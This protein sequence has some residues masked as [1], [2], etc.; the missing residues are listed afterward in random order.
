MGRLNII[1]KNK[2]IINDFFIETGTF[3]GESLHFATTLPF[4]K[5]YSCDVN[6]KYVEKAKQKFKNDNR[7]EIHHGSSHLILS[8]IIDPKIS[9]TFWLDAHWQNNHPD[10]IDFEVGECPLM[11]ELEI[12]FSQPWLKPPLV[13]IDDAAWFLY[14]NEN[15][16]LY[17][18]GYKTEQWPTY[19]DIINYLPQGTTNK[20]INDVIWVH[21]I[22]I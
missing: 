18:K 14:H 6:F 15:R 11:K 4:K 22:K 1:E 8:K 16:N 2:L 21:G 20:L 7:V 12:I 10:E 13:L 5:I 3:M 9:T 17:R 19:N